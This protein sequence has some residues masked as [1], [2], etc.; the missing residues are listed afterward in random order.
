LICAEDRVNAHHLPGLGKAFI[1]QR[2]PLWTSAASSLLGHNLFLPLPLR[3]GRGR[4]GDNRLIVLLILTAFFRILLLLALVAFLLAV[5][6]VD[7][8][9]IVD[10][11]VHG[12]LAAHSTE[13]T[14]GV[15][16]RGADTSQTYL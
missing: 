13:H 2:S 10:D 14:A 15:L 1:L 4:G 6:V 5:C 12:I 3:R 11:V 16:A 9:A 8:R 7:Y